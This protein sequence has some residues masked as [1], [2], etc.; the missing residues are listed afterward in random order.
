MTQHNVFSGTE[1][2][3]QNAADLALAQMTYKYE[4]DEWATYKQ[5]LEHGYQVQKGEKGVGIM[6]VIDD[7]EKSKKAVRYFRVFNVAQVKLIEE[8]EENDK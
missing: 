7:A 6:A 8:S 3:G 5:W 2:K 1:Y 4:S